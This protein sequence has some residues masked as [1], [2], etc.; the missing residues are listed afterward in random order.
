MLETQ[1]DVLESCLLTKRKV[2]RCVSVD[3]CDLL[4]VNS[5]G[6]AYTD[7]IVTS[8]SHNIIVPNAPPAVLGSLVDYECSSSSDTENEN[9]DEEITNNV[10]VKQEKDTTSD[11]EMTVSSSIVAP[12]SKDIIDEIVQRKHLKRKHTEPVTNSSAPKIPRIETSITKVISSESSSRRKNKQPKKVEYHLGARLDDAKTAA[13]SAV[14]CNSFYTADDVLPHLPPDIS[15]TREVDG[16]VQRPAAMV[17][18]PDGATHTC[19]LCEQRLTG[20]IALASHMYE[21]HG[22]DL[23]QVYS[24]TNT[25]P[26]L[27]VLTPAPPPVL[28]ASTACNKTRKIPELVKISDVLSAR[29]NKHKS[30]EPKSS[31]HTAAVSVYSDEPPVLEAQPQLDRPAPQSLLLRANTTNNNATSNN[32]FTCTECTEPVTYSSFREYT[33]HRRAQHQIFHCDL[34]PKFYGRNSHLWKH[35]NRVHKGHPSITCQQC[36]KTSASEYHL[37]QH[38]NKMHSAKP[39]HHHHHQSQYGSSRHMTNVKIK[40]EPLNN[41]SNLSPATVANAEE[42]N[43]LDGDDEMTASAVVVTA[44]D[45]EDDLLNQK[46]QG[47]D[48]KSVRQSFL[49]QELMMNKRHKYVSILKK[50]N[51]DN[52]DTVGTKRAGSKNISMVNS[53]ANHNTA[54]TLPNPNAPKEIDSSSDLYTNI[55]T[56]YTPPSNEGPYKCPK[57][58]KGFHKKNLLKKHKKNCRPRL[59][60]DL[61]TRCKTCSRIFKDRQSLAKHLVNYHS[62]YTCEI[63]GVAVQSKCEIVSHIR[64]THPGSPDLQCHCGQILRSRADLARH[65]ADHRD[66]HVCQFCGDALPTKI[67]LKM[68]ILSLH[69]KILSLSCGICLKLFETQHILK[70]HVRLVHGDQLQPLTSCTVCGKNY[71]SKWKT[72]DHLNKSHG[73]IFKACKACLDVFETERELQAHFEKEH[74]NNASTA[75]GAGTVSKHNQQQQHQ[76]LQAQLKQDESTP[77]HSANVTDNENDEEDDEGVKEDVEMPVLDEEESEVKQKSI[78][79]KQ[80]SLQNGFYRKQPTPSAISVQENKLSLLEKRLLGRK[81]SEEQQEQTS[82]H[83]PAPAAVVVAKSTN[84]STNNNRRY[85]YNI[86]HCNS[87]IYLYLFTELIPIRTLHRNKTQPNLHLWTRMA[88]S[89]RIHRVPLHQQPVVISCRT[90]PNVPCT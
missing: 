35:V 88:P 77:V 75:G 73:R 42:T 13:S 7:D 22:I 4:L 56:N 28:P 83:T 11:N 25:V 5:V 43:E 41:S 61:L 64:F 90:L 14:T 57:C 32:Q 72:Y 76:L 69:R 33:T 86:Y 63:C 50:K 9:D 10:R 37:A 45:D 78:E 30:T 24:H 62:E 67:K 81:V 87:Y 68:H 18:Q 82:K 26:P 39:Q 70:E 2:D 23:A 6:S 65:K 36:H 55:I 12:R 49:R 58:F 16:E 17:N 74:L 71:G 40:S 27:P 29:I 80:Q 48:F 34:C 3:V 47:F 89:K 66:S 38:F 8:D 51:S 46:F 59:Q 53:S 52:T 44:V 31:T 85:V 84:S 20:L 19:L 79:T 21:T 1:Y 60:K 15:V 54:N